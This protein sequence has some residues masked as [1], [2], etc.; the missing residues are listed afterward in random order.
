MYGRKPSIDCSR[1]KMRI[2]NWMRYRVTTILLNDKRGS[3][4]YDSMTRP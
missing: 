3:E 4:Q 2:L 1:C